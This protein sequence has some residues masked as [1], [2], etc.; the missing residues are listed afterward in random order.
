MPSTTLRRGLLPTVLLTA[1]ATVAWSLPASAATADEAAAD[2]AATYLDIK[3]T[4][5]GTVTGHFPDTSGKI[6]IFTDY[7]R[8]ID[9]ALGLLAAGGHDS[10]VGT[11]ITTLT[12]P[13]AVAEYTQGKPFDRADAAYAGATAKLAFFVEVTGGDARSVGGVDLLAQLR[14]L[15]TAQG[16]LADRSAFGDFANL[17]GH[18]FALLA[19]DTAGQTPSQELVQGLLSAQCPD[20]S[21]PETYEP[22]PDTACTGSVDATGLVLQGLAAVDLGSS[23]AAESA[24]S[25]LTSQQQADGS[26]PGEAPVNSTGYAVMGLN[27]VGAPTGE[28]VSYLASQQNSDGGLRRGAGESNASDV[29]ATAQALPALAGATLQSGARPVA[30]VAVPC[31]NGASTRVHAK[32]ITA[33]ELGHVRVTAAS[34][35]TVDLYAYSRPGTEYR[36][37]RT[38]IVGNNGV[39]GFVVRPGTNTRMYAQQRDCAAGPST[40]LEV[41][42]F[43]TLNVVRNGPQD[44]TF[45]GRLIPARGLV[46]NLYR[47]TGDGRHVLTAQV[48]AGANGLWSYRRVFTGTGRFGFVTTTGRDIVN[49]PGRSATQSVLIH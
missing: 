24:T 47:I 34:G 10:T 7:G 37:V 13:A 2:R 22:Q 31:G 32:E 3:V 8:S 40:V 20:G 17:F 11:A 41:R 14:S 16:R 25:W 44:Y 48:R 26:F 33:T 42:M 43:Q 49:T 38:G 46:V 36:K 45:S 28:A 1:A 12:K 35:S 21:F 18:S 6:V 15:V 9:A 23:A 27:A 29:F 4:D 39:A 19:I 30:S 5:A